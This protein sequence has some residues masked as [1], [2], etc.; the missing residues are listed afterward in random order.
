M[1]TQQ[2]LK[3]IQ[4][5]GIDLETFEEQIENFKRGFP[6]IDLVAP[7]TLEDGIRNFSEAEIKVLEKTY[8]NEAPDRSVLKFVP[9]SGA[10]SRMFKHLFAFR[11]KL[12]G[13][14]DDQKLLESDKG[15]HS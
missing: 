3:Q 11:E 15:F 1:L 4:S 14:A 8:N 9:A 13:T 12:T 2:D 7:A 5:K 6:F 10:A